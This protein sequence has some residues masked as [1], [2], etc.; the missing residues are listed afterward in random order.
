MSVLVKYT[1]CMYWCNKKNFES[2]RRCIFVNKNRKLWCFESTSS[3]TAVQCRDIFSDLS[4]QSYLQVDWDIIFQSVSCVTFVYK[5]GIWLNC[6]FFA[7]FLRLNCRTT[8]CYFNKS[9]QNMFNPTSTKGIL[10]VKS[11]TSS[12]SW[13]AFERTL[14]T[15]K[16]DYFLFQHE[17]TFGISLDY[18]GREQLVVFAHV[19][20][21]RTAAA[22]IVFPVS[23]VFLS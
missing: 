13:I 19:K 16:D 15:L 1:W 4:R 23:L 21:K 22:L 7:S 11:S 5:N 10:Q 6:V 9:S 12:D 17:L 3:N 2:S 8:Y 18:C 14:H 20:C